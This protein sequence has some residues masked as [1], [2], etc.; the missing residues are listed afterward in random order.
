MG[1]P[2]RN[3]RNNALIYPQQLAKALPAGCSYPLKWVA[4]LPPPENCSIR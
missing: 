4:M 2:V 3:Q 1:F